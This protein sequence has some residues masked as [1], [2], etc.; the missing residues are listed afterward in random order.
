MHPNGALLI[1]SFAVECTQE[2]IRDIGRLVA[3]GELPDI[4]I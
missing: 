3:E 4:P 1:R 2:L